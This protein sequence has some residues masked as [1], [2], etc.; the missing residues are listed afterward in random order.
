MSEK[1]IGTKAVIKENKDDS[2]N[3]MTTI[4]ELWNLVTEGTIKGTGTVTIT[5]I[6]DC[7]QI[8]TWDTD[9]IKSTVKV[10]ESSGTTYLQVAEGDLNLEELKKKLG[11]E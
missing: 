1:E 3:A 7:P 11:I 6:D 10:Q 4:Q 2:S 9:N 8:V 5:Y